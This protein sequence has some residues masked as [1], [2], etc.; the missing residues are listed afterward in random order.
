L[1]NKNPAY[2]SANKTV[3]LEPPSFHTPPAR[4]GIYAFVW[5]Y[6]DLF[7]L[8]GTTKWEYEKDHKGEKVY[9][10]DWTD[11]DGKPVPEKTIPKK[12]IPKM[13]V[14]DYYGD[15]WHHLKP[16]VQK[17]KILAERG[18]WVKTSFETFVEALKKEV[19]SG[20]SMDVLKDFRDKDSGY[21]PNWKRTGKP[22]T[23]IGTDHLEVFI[24]DIH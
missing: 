23:N 21:N 2:S 18:D 5:P 9:Y 10:G 4:K 13:R 11:K 1:D 24:E 8:N 7:L 14:F 12:T 15:I 22:F 17:N 16:H 6:I 19:H 3:A 20:Y